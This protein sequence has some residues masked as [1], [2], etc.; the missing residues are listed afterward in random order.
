MIDD[1]DDEVPRGFGA[2]LRGGRDPAGL[3]FG[4]R[5]EAG[6]PPDGI[7]RPGPRD[8]VFAPR[9]PV[10]LR[11]AG[12]SLT[13]RPYEVVAFFRCTQENPK[14]KFRAP[15]GPGSALICFDALAGDGRGVHRTTILR[16]IGPAENPR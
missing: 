11:R 1:T 16:L 7:A 5:A 4:G 2:G 14:C 13:F 6:P 8:P 15:R 12:R 3:R 10:R 9:R